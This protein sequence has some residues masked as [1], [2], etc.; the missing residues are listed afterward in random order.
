V[1]RCD[2]LSCIFWLGISILVCVESIRSDLGTLRLPGPGFFPFV[3]GVLIATCAIIL[4]INSRIS[5]GVNWKR[6]SKVRDLWKSLEW[7]RVVLALSSLFLYIGLLQVM[8]YFITTFALMT[9]LLCI[10]GRSK[11]VIQG[12]IALIIVSVSY[13]IFDVLLDVQLP[14]GIFGF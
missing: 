10:M 2:H 13:L 9:F 6:E 3:L 7:K 5:S 4:M 8:G 14:K 1:N 11:V 12:M